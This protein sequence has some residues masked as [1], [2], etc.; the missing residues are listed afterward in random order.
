MNDFI[1]KMELARKCVGIAL[2]AGASQVRVSLSKSVTDTVS[3]LNGE[4]DK[5]SHSADQSIFLHVFVDGRYG[6]FSTNRLDIEE[7][8]IF[9]RKAVTATGLLAPDTLHRL[10]DNEI[11]ASDAKDGREAGLFDDSYFDI[12]SEKRLDFADRL[13]RPDAGSEAK[14]RIVSV[15]AEYSDNIDDNFIV[16]SNG[17]EGRHTETEFTVSSEVTI[18]DHDGN[19]LS[20]FWWDSSPFI[21]KLRFDASDIALKRAVMSI[22]PGKIRSGLKNMVVDRSVASRLVSP[23]IN[24]LY[25]SNIQQKNSFLL[26]SVGSKMFGETFSLADHARMTGHPGARL[27]DTEG[28]ATMDRQVIENGVVKMYFIDTYNSGKLGLRQTIEGPSVPTVMPSRKG[29]SLQDLLDAAGTGILVT[30]FNGGNCNSATGDFSYGVEGFVIKGAKTYQTPIREM[31][32]TGNM[33]DLWTNLVLAADDAR[34]CSRWQVP[35]LFF[36]DVHF[37]I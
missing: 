22:G 26:G 12:T 20:G 17:F 31:V 36:K 33:K 15:E 5:V 28:V 14:F 3:M 13:S 37:S 10:P 21:E 9:V 30:G 7:L 35:S 27:F 32:I 8:T 34:G 19:K 6:T 25:A 4:L 18:Q 23:I 11:C 2:N 24:A 16:D 29:A 1:N